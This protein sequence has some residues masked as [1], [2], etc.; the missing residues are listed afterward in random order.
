MDFLWAYF[1]K[2]TKI[3]NT[4]SQENT[5]HRIFFSKV[6]GRE[7]NNKSGEINNNEVAFS[8][9]LFFKRTCFDGNFTL[10]LYVIDI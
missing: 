3:R 7:L 9:A 1:D 2:K 8:N 5:Y 6:S 4:P 10:I